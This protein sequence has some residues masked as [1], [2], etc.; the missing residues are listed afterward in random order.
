M[1]QPVLGFDP[2]PSTNKLPK[3]PFHLLMSGN[4]NI[5]FFFG[6]N[7]R[8][9]P[10]GGREIPMLLGGD[11]PRIL[12]GR[13]G[14]SC[15]VVLRFCRFWKFMFALHWDTYFDGGRFKEWSVGRVRRGVRGH[16][17]NGWRSPLVGAY[18]S[19][20]NVIPLDFWLC[21]IKFRTTPFPKKKTKT[22]VG[23]LSLL[24]IRLSL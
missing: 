21:I 13:F 10:L 5:K 18:S 2:R 9:R 12:S 7:K 24:W 23:E 4:Q 22:F 16:I 17:S 1:K 3:T 20:S 11:C 15:R 19:S 8:S 14:K 6:E